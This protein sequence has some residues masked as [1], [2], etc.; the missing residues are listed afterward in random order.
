MLIAI[1]FDGTL[2]EDAELWR[3]FIEFAKQLGHRVICVT[4]RCDTEDDNDT[5][6]E[7]MI[8]HDIKLP[9][10]YTSR[11]SK[12]AHMEAVGIKVDIWIEDNPMQCVM[13]F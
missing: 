10:Y 1:D 8:K 4:A 3:G 6:D 12:V 7:W 11:G 5:V 9:I 13:G 2:T